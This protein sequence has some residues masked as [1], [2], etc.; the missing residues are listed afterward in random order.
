MIQL[1]IVFRALQLVA[2]H[3]HNLTKGLTFFEDHDFFGDLYGKAEGYYDSVVERF[4]GLGYESH[5]KLE[6]ILMEVA[7]KVSIMKLEEAQPKDFYLNCLAL[8]SE[9]NEMINKFCSSGQL[10]EG[11][12]QLLGGIADELEVLKYKIARKMK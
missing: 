12:K 5:L 8:I 1:I 6:M 11:T 3:A 7:K 9:S 10:T 4:I 2:H